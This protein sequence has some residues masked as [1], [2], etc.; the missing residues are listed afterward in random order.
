M[1]TNL[2]VYTRR[3]IANN[4]NINNCLRS[5]GVAFPRVSRYGHRTSVE[6]QNDCSGSRLESVFSSDVL[7]SARTFF[8]H[9]TS[10][11][12]VQRF[13]TAKTLNGLYVYIRVEVRSGC[14]CV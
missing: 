12:I 11:K 5:T 10:A 9:G 3:Y 14:V 1:Y 7:Y 4:Y 2:R 13:T 8:I 6:I